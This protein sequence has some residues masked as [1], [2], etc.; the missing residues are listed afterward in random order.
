MRSLDYRQ[1]RLADLGKANDLGLAA[2]LP[3]DRIAPHTA[4]HDDRPESDSS[5]KSKFEDLE[6]LLD[7]HRPC[8]HFQLTLVMV[9]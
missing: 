7:V 6:R 5:S 8:S 2:Q 9:W 1:F 4:A 3:V